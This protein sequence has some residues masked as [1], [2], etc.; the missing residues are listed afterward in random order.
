MNS[1]DWDKRY[2]EKELVW[3]AGPNQF[4]VQ[5]VATMAAGRALD[6][7]CGEG[8]NAIWLAEQGWQVAAS[9]YS[10]V[11]IEKAKAR[12]AEL[13][14]DVDLKV[15]DAAAEASGEFD[16]VALFYL[17][18]PRDE[19]R[20]VLANACT[21]LAPGG[22]LLY[23]GHDARNI[24]EGIGGPQDPTIL[25]SPDEITALLPTLAIQRAET[26]QRPVQREDKT[27]QALDLL[28]RATKPV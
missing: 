11:A 1:R 10:P 26:I 25:Y 15:A 8:R 14:L 9:D 5:E 18:L 2:R 17:H 28:V 12:C 7:A 23:V 3:S 24:E 21:A 6:L 22:T 20:A 19:N 27:Y 16:L 4:L 13:K